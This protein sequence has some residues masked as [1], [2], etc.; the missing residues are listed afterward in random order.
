[1]VGAP[2]IR[3][4][5]ICWCPIN[6]GAPLLR[7]P[8]RCGCPINEGA[9]E[10]RVPS[11]FPPWSGFEECLLVR[12]GRQWE[13][14]LSLQQPS[15]TQQLSLAGMCEDWGENRPKASSWGGQL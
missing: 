5:Q 11:A 8:W 7:V 13:G 2:L 12:G 3:V 1:M 14:L 4:S 15:V 9:L 6:V 10:M